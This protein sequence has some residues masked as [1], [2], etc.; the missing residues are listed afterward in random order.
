[1]ARLPRVLATCVVR[2]AGP[3]E[4]HGGVYAIDLETGTSSLALD[5]NDPDI[6]WQGRG[7]ERGLRGVAVHRSG[8]Y[9]ATCDEILQ[10]DE[11]FRLQRAFGHKYLGHLHEIALA[12][13]RLWITSTAYD[14]VLELDLS[15]GRFVRGVCLR[16]VDSGLPAFELFDPGSGHGPLPGDTTHLNSVVPHRGA[17]YLSGADLP[18]LCV[19]EHDEL[20]IWSA[21]P[22][23][24]HNARPYGE[25]VILNDSVARRLRVL[26]PFGTERASCPGGGPGAAADGDPAGAGSA[27]GFTR[28][29]CVLDDDLVAFGSSPAS[30]RVFSVSRARCLREIVLSSDVRRSI[31]GIAAWP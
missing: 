4:S 5:W 7:G 27:P 2:T 15:T 26:G 8:I 11:A 21:I 10:F 9:V 31:H 22:L 12:G 20:R 28:G 19:L 3:G 16:R 24:S 17:L 6:D 23:G 29:L 18:F 1:M 14:A 30:V 25:G 13:E